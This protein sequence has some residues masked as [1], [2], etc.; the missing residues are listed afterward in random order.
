MGHSIDV[1]SD[2]P[3]AA[4]TSFAFKING[5]RHRLLIFRPTGEKVPKSS[6]A[7]FGS[8]WV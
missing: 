6:L 2:A 3:S 8:D 1:E 7:V 5:S 4:W